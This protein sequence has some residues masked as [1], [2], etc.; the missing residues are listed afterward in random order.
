MSEPIYVKDI[1]K[2]KNLLKSIELHSPEKEF[3]KRQ[4]HYFAQLGELIEQQPIRKIETKEEWEILPL[5]KTTSLPKE[6]WTIAMGSKYPTYISTC[7][8]CGEGHRWATSGGLSSFECKKCKTR[9][10]PC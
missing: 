9:F 6:D 8:N 10:R 4:D 1:I 5:S 7:P 2:D 3:Q